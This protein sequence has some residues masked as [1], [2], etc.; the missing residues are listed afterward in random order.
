MTPSER[1][2]ETSSAPEAV[3][4]SLTICVIG[5]IWTLYQIP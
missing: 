2:S 3:Y 5:Y 1:R 4:P